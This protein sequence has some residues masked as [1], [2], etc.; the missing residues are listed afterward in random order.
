M[1]S[2][3]ICMSTFSSRLEIVPD[4]TITEPTKVAKKD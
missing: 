4:L 1:A 2:L 3:S